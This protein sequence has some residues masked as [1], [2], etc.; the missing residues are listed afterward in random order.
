MF[1]MSTFVNKRWAKSVCSVCILVQ[2]QFFVVGIATCP[3]GCILNMRMTAV[4]AMSLCVM[5]NCDCSIYDLTPAYHLADCISGRHIPEVFWYGFE[6][7]WQLMSYKAGYM[8]TRVGQWVDMGSRSL[9]RVWP[10]LGR[11][12]GRQGVENYKQCARGVWSEYEE[13][14]FV[15]QGK[16]QTNTKSLLA[17]CLQAGSPTW[18]LSFSPTHLSFTLPNTNSQLVTWKM[19]N[20]YILSGT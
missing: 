17:K 8:C 9:M 6:T 20:I 2:F 14:Y 5:R 12:W 19:C 16:L 11:L 7:N 4:V 18:Q 3:S 15:L 10:Q 1:W 13:L